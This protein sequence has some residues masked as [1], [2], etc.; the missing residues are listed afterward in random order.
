LLAFN[1]NHAK[2]ARSD[3]VKP[4]VPAEVRNIYAVSPG[5]V[6]EHLA[7]LGLHFLFI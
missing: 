1:L 6:Y 5:Y 4:A 2:P 7:F 3:P